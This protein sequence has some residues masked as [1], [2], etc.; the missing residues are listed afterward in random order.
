VHDADDHLFF[1][2]SGRST[3]ADYEA[4]QHVDEAVVADIAEWITALKGT[5]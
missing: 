3:P 2:G 4:A 1:P 5:P